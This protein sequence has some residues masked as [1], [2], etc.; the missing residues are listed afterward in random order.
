MIF[1]ATPTDGSGG[2]AAAPFVDKPA[3]DPAAATAA[4]TDPVDYKALLLQLLDLDGA[5]DDAA[6]QAAFAKEEAEP[7]DDIEALKTQAASAT[8]LQT[9]LDAKSAEATQ[10]YADMEAL[11]K[12]QAEAQADD[13]LK[14]YEGQFTDDASKAAIRAILVSDRESGI[15]IL[16]GLKKPDAAAAPSGAAAAADD[17]KT[18]PPNPQHDPAAQQAGAS[19]QETANK[20]SARAREIVKNSNPKVSMT[21]A[22]AQAERELK[23]AA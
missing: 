12:Q 2:G 20:I 17:T 4:A 16:N 1:S 19:E 11:R 8:D 15:A 13:I 9:Q 14:V 18:T 6:I 22:Y 3:T 21:K 5:A 7:E 10:A 23:A